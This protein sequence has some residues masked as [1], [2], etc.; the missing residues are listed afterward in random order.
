MPSVERPSTAA[1]GARVNDGADVGDREEVDDL[2]T[3]GFE[4]DFNL[5]ERGAEGVRLA[6]VRGFVAGGGDE[7]GAGKGQHGGLQG[8]RVH[9]FGRLMAVVFAADLNGVL[10]G[11]R[12]RHA[13]SAAFAGDAFIGDHVIACAPAELHGGCPAQFLDVSFATA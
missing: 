13:G 2:V 7:A 9:V 11:L 1:E 8:H 12:E 10:G 6:I 5:G 3:A 4:I